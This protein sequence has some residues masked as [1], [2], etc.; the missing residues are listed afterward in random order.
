[1]SFGQRVWWSASA[2]FLPAL[3]CA[4]LA[5]LLFA[6]GCAVDADTYGDGRATRGGD[7]SSVVEPRLLGATALQVGPRLEVRAEVDAPAGALVELGIGWS[8]GSVDVAS[9]EV[10]GD[11][12]AALLVELP[13]A[14]AQL[15][16][17]LAE[18]VVSLD[19]WDVDV[20][21]ALEGELVDTDADG[22]AV[23]SDGMS[24]LCGTRP[25]IDAWVSETAPFD[26]LM[27]GGG[28]AVLSYEDG[29]G[30]LSFGPGGAFELRAGRWTVEPSSK[31]YALAVVRR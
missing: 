18:A 25:S 28:R 17:G 30:G 7:D 13:D 12:R 29:S 27:L 16:A 6:P 14:C 23:L 24:L 20:A 15:G 11:G 26:L 3:A 31:A 10:D 8:T 4:L 19:G 22:S 1:M 2:A 21:V 5:S 9:V